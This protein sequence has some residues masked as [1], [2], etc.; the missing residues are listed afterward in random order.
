MH[1]RAKEIVS[2]GDKL[3][4]DKQQVDSLNQEIALNFYPDRADFTTKRNEGEEYSDHLFS[5]YPSLCRRELGNM[6]DEFLFPEKW[7]SIHVDDEELDEGDEERRFL[8]R[9]T[10]IQW[11]AMNDA[12]ANLVTAR[13]QTNHDFSSFG[14]GV[15]NYGLNVRGDALL[16]RNYHLRDV[17]WS[18]NAEGRIDCVHRNWCPTARQL[19]H[20]FGKDV[21]EQVMK[22][23]E[24]EP[25]K[26]FRCRHVVMPSRLYEY[27]SKGGKAF[28]FVSLFVEIETDK[29]LEEVGQNWLGYVIPRWQVVSG[30]VYGRSM[31]TS[32]LLPDGRTIQVVMRTLREAAEKYVD[33]PMLA[34]GDAIRG[35]IALYAG[36]ITNAD[37]EYDERLGEVLRPVTRD[38]GGMP[39][40]FEIASAL[41]ED[42]R[43]G[44]FLDKIQLPETSRAM[45]ATEVRRRI[46]E[47]IR[48][49]AP[50]SK[51]IQKE[52]NDP[53]CDGTFQILL[54]NN[55]FPMDEMP[56][57]LQ[58]HELKFKFRSPLD[59][60]AEQNEADIF[61]DVRDR[62]LMPSAQL[63]PSLIETADL[64]EATRDAMRSA[65]WKAKWFKP[66]E[67]VDTRREQQAQDQE[68]AQMAQEAAQIGQIAEQGGKGLDAL[69]TAGADVM[70]PQQGA[71]SKMSVV[72]GGRR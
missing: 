31:A 14:N 41:K 25:D 45:T 66:K 46:Q 52:Y 18:E 56:E 29:V 57:S 2:Q 15:I 30:S 58:G 44:F 9:L 43:S 53:L 47:H 17:V 34:I 6:L 42:I 4:G 67:A 50:I 49:A 24:K 10:E 35:D 12:R 68:A 72:Q 65:G 8:E 55:V 71:Q 48:A 26:I 69:M 21:S 39:I 16:Y 59:E 11:R 5:S 36:G 51:P 40:G 37:I 64:A 19:K 60:L 27:K 20:H 28:P 7:L 32:I 1:A 63:D 22:A 61:V 70:P 13:S 33:P 62:I 3:F 54:E 23:C 38:R